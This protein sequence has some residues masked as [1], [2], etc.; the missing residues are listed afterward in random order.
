MTSS[1]GDDPERHRQHVE[2]SVKR[3][4]DA[5]RAIALFAAGEDAAADEAALWDCRAKALKP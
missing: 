4:D 1:L 2:A 5:R 3:D